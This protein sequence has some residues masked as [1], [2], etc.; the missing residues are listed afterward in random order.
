MGLTAVRFFLFLTALLLWCLSPSPDIGVVLAAGLGLVPACGGCCGSAG[1]I[2][3]SDNFS[4]DNLATDWDNRSGSW[5]VS[6]GA[7]SS[8]SSS[9]L[10]VTVA[11]TDGVATGAHLTALLYMDTTSDIGLLILGYSDDDNYW[12]LEVQP[13]AANGTLKLF[14]R[15]GGV[16][17]QLG[18]TQ[19]ITGL[20]AGQTVTAC[21]SIGGGAIVA[22]TTFGSERDSVLSFGS[23]AM[24][25]TAAGVGTGSGSSYVEFDDVQFKEHRADN[26]NCG[27][28]Q[29]TTC[30]ALC[31]S[32]PASMTLTFDGFTDGGDANS[33]TCCEAA[34]SAF[35]IKKTSDCG[36]H[37]FNA[38]LLI[39]GN[40]CLTGLIGLDGLMTWDFSANG[41]D[42]KLTVT[43][44]QKNY[45]PNACGAGPST[46]QYS[47]EHTVGTS[48]ANCETTF[49]LTYL[50]DS[51]GGTPEAC[52]RSAT[53][54]CTAAF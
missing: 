53:P 48:P 16:D 40:T 12:F 7:L 5:S 36:G 42:T 50:G 30:T 43:M 9:A 8:T 41:G 33:C 18:S 22:Q 32:V 27:N 29:V 14:E 13:G 15:A 1:C 49:S 47:W 34:N 4:S 25:N 38:G 31:T 28:C 6:G 21:L 51:V 2:I 37:V 24:A 54:T 19:T 35:V 17:L 11:E 20:I 23:P 26:E 45:G 39:G 44:N 10:I 46:G 52:D 3:F